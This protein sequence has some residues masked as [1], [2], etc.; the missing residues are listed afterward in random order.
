MTHSEKIQIDKD[1]WRE[2][3]ENMKIDLNRII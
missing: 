1:S 3:I 2:K